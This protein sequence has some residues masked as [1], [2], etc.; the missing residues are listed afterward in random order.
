MLDANGNEVLDDALNRWGRLYQEYCCTGLAK[1]ETQRLKWQKMNQKTLRAEKYDKVRAAVAEHDAAGATGDLQAGKRVVLASSFTGGPRDQQQRYYDSMAVV[2]KFGAPSFFITMTCNP[3]WPE[4]VASLTENHTAAD[5]ADLNARVFRIKCDE[6]ICDLKTRGIFGRAVAF[7]HV[8][9]FQHRGLP[10]AHILIILDRAHRLNSVDEID[11]CVSAEIPVKPKREAFPLG[12]DGDEKY[13]DALEAWKELA[14]LVCEHMEHGPC[15]RENRHAPC[16]QEDGTCKRHYP[17]PFLSETKR[18]DGHIYPEY[19]R[20]SV[21]MGGQ[22]HPKKGRTLD[23]SNIVPYSPHL[24]LKYRCHLN[25]EACVSIQGV[26][27]L[28]KYVYKGGDR[29]MAWARFRRNANLNDKDEVEMYQDLRSLGCSESCWKT[30]DFPMYSRHPSVVRLDIHLE[31]EQSCQF[32]DGDERRVVEEGPPVTSLNTWLTFLKSASTGRAAMGPDSGWELTYPDFPERYLYNRQ[33][34]SWG[35]RKKGCGNGSVI[36]RVRNVHPVEGALFYL[37]LLL[38]HVPARDIAISNASME[39][40]AADA[41]TYEAFKYVN[42]VK[43]ETY[44][45]A[46]SV[47]GLLQDDGEWHEAMEDASGVKMPQSIRALFG[48]ILNF[49]EPQDPLQL[50]ESFWEKMGE[51]YRRQLNAAHGNAS[52]MM[53]RAR[54]LLDIEQRVQSH[55]NQLSKFNLSLSEEERSLAEGA[56]ATMMQ[57]AEPKEIRDELI[58]VAERSSLA[59]SA[60]V[61]YATL[62]ESQ[63]VLYHAVLAAI[64]ARDGRRIFVDAPGGTGKTYTFNTI[65]AALRAEGHIVLAVASSGIAAIL[66]DL[67]RTF[68]SRFK[69]ERLHPAPDQALNISAQTQ[70]AAL[71]RRATAIFWDEAAMGNKFHLEALDK[72][73]HDFMGTTD[74]RLANVPFGGKTIV[75]GGD[76][77]QTLPIVRFASRAQTVDVA[78]TRSRLWSDF[79]VF[80]LEENMRVEKAREQ[81]ERSFEADCSEMDS[82]A[83]AEILARLQAFAEWLLRLGNGEEPGDELSHVMLPSECCLPEGCDLDALVSWVYPNLAANCTNTEWLSGRAI[84]APYNEEV[85][86]INEK[87]SKSFPGDEIVCLSADRTT[88]PED[89]CAAPAEVLNKI[90][91]NGMPQ[92]ELRLKVNMPIMLLRNLSP[93]DGLCNGTR[94]LVRRV[95]NGRV[96]EAEIATGHHCGKVVHIPRIKLS[97]DDGLYPWAW[98]W[99]Q[100][101]VRVAIAM[102]INKAQGQTFTRVGIYLERPCFSHGQLYVAASRVGLPENIMFAVA[103][104]A[105][106]EFRTAN[107]VYDE[108]LTG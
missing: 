99:L 70:L 79:T 82:N 102:T 51:D 15:G 13:E 108:A 3:K 93:I 66:L 1:I 39:A 57:F 34:K 48:Y 43:H 76:F 89:D 58:P 53:V 103:P 101:P 60:E 62:K 11:A 7:L 95:I 91:P 71:L 19:R 96:L 50:F 52:D 104:N 49:N 2:R 14:D 56:V 107:V 29:C 26:K 4:I 88:D 24:L 33:Q 78:L 59:E 74:P 98:S 41:F 5:R 30:F 94:L 72:T 21:Q 25:V 54:V 37:R 90:N 106:G 17:K 105:A 63:Q 27:Y 81:L 47:R 84:L 42:G 68:H 20:R 46:C 61:R 64:R 69:A 67:G 18:P 65:L 23:N 45:A 6:L 36:G 31:G 22:T 28:Y 40:V 86:A 80:C 83:R 12:T 9:E 97:P 32:E 92:H 55:G 85:S 38:H 35:L 75:L 10:H 77:R 100:F 87:V 16:M 73:L 44:K 8:I